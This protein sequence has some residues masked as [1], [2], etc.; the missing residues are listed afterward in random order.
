[1]FDAVLVD[2]GDAVAD[3]LAIPFERISLEMIYRG[4]YH[5]TMAHHQGK[6]TAPVKYF[7][8]PENR[9]LG[10][11]KQERKPNVKLIVA[12]FPE[13]QRGSDQFFFKNSPKASWQKAYSLNLSPMGRTGELPPTQRASWSFAAPVDLPEVFLL[14]SKTKTG[15]MDEF[16]YVNESFARVRDLFTSIVK[17]H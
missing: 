5:F 12:P 6:A 2:L 3:E 17:L 7:A 1:L 14:E 8:A 11:I 16:T 4:L 15:F 10:I 9:D 13:K